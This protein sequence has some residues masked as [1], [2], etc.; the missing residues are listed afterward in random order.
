MVQKLV[1]LSVRTLWITHTSDSFRTNTAQKRYMFRVQQQMTMSV[2]TYVVFDDPK[3]DYIFCLHALVHF[4]HLW[5]FST[6]AKV[7]VREKFHFC[8]IRE[9]LCSQK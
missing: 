7:N 4:D 1:N 6:F 5:T 8:G 9:S 2:K 3:L